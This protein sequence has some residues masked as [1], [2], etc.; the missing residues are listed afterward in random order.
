MAFKIFA[1]R[2]NQELDNM[3]VPQHD[4]E[5]VEAFRR[6]IDTQKFKAASILHGEIMPSPEILDKIAKVLEVDIEWLVG[7]NDSA[8]H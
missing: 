1:E 8:S 6:L 4:D 5:R 2:L 3:G 7:K